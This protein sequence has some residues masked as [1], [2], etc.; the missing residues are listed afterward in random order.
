MQGAPNPQINVSH[1][2]GDGGMAG[3][4]FAVICTLVFLIGIPGLRLF[5]PVAFLLGVA[6]AAV[7]HRL[8]QKTLGASWIL[9]SSRE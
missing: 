4:I 1:I 5:L 7:I 2:P 6:V 3:A 9:P 8:P